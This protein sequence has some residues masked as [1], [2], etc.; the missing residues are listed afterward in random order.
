MV[1]EGLEHN[2]C[3]KKYGHAGGKRY[4]QYLEPFGPP[5]VVPEWASVQ[6]VLGRPAIICRRPHCSTRLV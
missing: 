6:I 5:V 1:S 2:A 4:K 3:H